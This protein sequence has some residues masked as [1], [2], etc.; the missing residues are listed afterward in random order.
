M[1]WRV[2]AFVQAGLGALPPRLGDPLYHALQR[3]R[4]LR[5][6]AVGHRDLVRRLERA[7]AAEGAAGLPGR[8]VV[9]LGSGWFPL[10]PLLLLARGARRVQTFDTAEHYSPARIRAAAA[11]LLAEGEA[12]RVIEEA[13]GTGRLPRSVVYRPRTRL[14]AAEGVE[15]ADL[16]VSRFT[17]EHVPAETIA[18]IHRRSRDWMAPGGWWL[19]WV[20]PSDHRAY[21]DRRLSLVDF[22]RYSDA[23]WARIAGNRYAYHNRLRRSDYVLLFAEAGWE[24]CAEEGE[25]SPA[26]M[27]ALGELPL[28]EKY[29]G[30][31]FEDLAASSLWFSLRARSADEPLPKAVPLEDRAA[32]DGED[33]GADPEGR[34]QHAG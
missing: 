10:T 2:K 22:L 20:S 1:D 6:N 30:R 28:A 4:G 14:E 5:P 19:H 29:R 16:G 3:R 27:A 9:E 7:L 34:A 33:S 18:A 31:P 32:R 21:D 12:H 17:L 24:V 26:Q 13:A 25:A 23:E 15:R 8:S 11:A